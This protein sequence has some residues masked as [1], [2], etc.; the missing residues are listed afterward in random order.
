MFILNISDVFLGFAVVISK[1]PYYLYAEG[2]YNKGA[3]MTP[4]RDQTS[5]SN[6][7]GSLDGGTP[8][9][10]ALFMKSPKPKKN[11]SETGKPLHSLKKSLF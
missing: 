10:H 7:Q 9:I 3:H 4:Y 2:N 8:P 11:K 1:A 5:W 6:D